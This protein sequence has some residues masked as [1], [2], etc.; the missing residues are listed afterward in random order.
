[1]TALARSPAGAYLTGD[2]SGVVRRFSSSGV[3]SPVP[4]TGHTNLVVSI[5]QSGDDFY[6]TSFDDSLKKL[7][8][9][10]YSCVSPRALP[11]FRF[12]HLTFFPLRST[13]LSTGAIPKGL[14]PG[15]NGLL[16]LATAS[17]LQALSSGS[18]V[19]SLS[20]SY[21]PTSIA[22]S[23]DGS[24]V[25]VGG[26][27]SKC[28]LYSVKT[29]GAFERVTELPLRVAVTAVAFSPDSS[30]SLPP[31]PSAFISLI[32]PPLSSFYWYVETRRRR[33]RRQDPPLRGLHR[34]APPRALLVP[35]G[36]DQLARVPPGGRPPRFRVAR[37][38]DQGVLAREA[39]RGEGREERP[40]G[41]SEPGRVGGGGVDECWSGRGRQEVGVGLRRGRGGVFVSV[42]KCE[43][44]WA[45]KD[46]TARLL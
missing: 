15:P 45:L 11:R 44:S 38:V 32:T 18:K 9:A 12:L 27:D 41:R 31:L 35:V 46:G 36:A 37:R 2:S 4:G 20:V 33:R 30:V 23:S 28:Y 21:T 42:L 16:Y 40:P 17:S 22:A 10:E 43:V 1:M 14:A 24:F 6:S 3:C 8:T 29:P 13:S 19:A 39:E 34:Q 7:T 26:E 25:A 5:V